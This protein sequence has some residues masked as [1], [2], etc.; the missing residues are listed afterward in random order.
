M[1]KEQVV[2][3]PLKQALAEI[4]T[5]ATSG[6]EKG[7]D[8]LSA[9]LP[10]VIEQLLLW[11]MWESLVGN[12]LLWLFAFIIPAMLV[13]GNFKEGTR[14]FQRT[15]PRAP[16]IKLIIGALWLLFGLIPV[17]TANDLVWLQIWLAPK[18][19]LIEYAAQLIK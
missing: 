11:K 17:S 6:I 14:N 1:T 10:D 19:Y 2:V 4:L 8:F 3:D 13:F 12:I 15:E 5:K 18:I 7:I 9:E 16:G